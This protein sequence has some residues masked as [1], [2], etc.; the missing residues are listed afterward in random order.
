MSNAIPRIQLPINEPVRSYAPG[1]PERAEL[2]QALADLAQ[3]PLD[4]PLYIGGEEVRTGKLKPVTAPHD[5]SQVLAQ[6][7]QAG[8]DEM[9]AA[10]E[11]ALEAQEAWSEMPWAHRLSVFRRAA[12]LLA[13]PHRA[14]VNAATMLG[15]SKNA[16]QAEIDSACEQIDFWRFNAYFAC[17]LLAEQ[18]PISPTG[19]WNRLEMRPLEGF[20]FAVSPFNFTSIGGN[21]PTAPAML[22]NVAVWKPAATAVL[23]NWLLMQV[24]REAGLP[25]GVINFVSGPSS[26]IGDVA[27][28]HPSLAG[29]HFTGSTG[30]FQHMVRTV[31]ENI[32]NYKSYPRVCGETGGKDFVFAHPSA[33]VPR[34]VTALTRGAF[35]YQGQKCS[36]ASRAYIPQSLWPAVEAGLRRDLESI[37]V[38]SPVDFR[39]FVNAV[40]SRQAYDEITGYIK[41]AQQSP[42]AEVLIGGEFDDSKGYFVHPTVIR[43]K[44]PD[45]RCMVEEIFGPVL[46]IYVYPDAEF[47]ET[48]ALCDRS[49]PYALTGAVFANDRYAI[50]TA[51]R[52]LK[53]AAGNFY[54]NDKPTGAVVGQQPFGGARASGT[55]DKAGSSLNL[56]RW[57]SPRTI[58]E[59]FNPPSDYRYR[60]LEAE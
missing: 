38:G 5:H 42:D 29:V 17:Q 1:S 37:S 22:G 28:K 19:I 15:Q 21:L 30:V 7:H 24:L 60:F 39:N 18:P 4:I 16:Y 59:N 32:A 25:G 53:N 11:A 54:I 48:L 40:I 45:Y 44:K 9:H 57:L 52:A 51:D 36:A 50:Q 13:G 49:S 58:K 47:E 56:M 8:P 12:Q 14:R 2:K 26:Q 33:D 46:T 55:N 3:N 20:V 34:L 31:G 6:V 23:S 10:I 35:E 43:A 27:L 41:H